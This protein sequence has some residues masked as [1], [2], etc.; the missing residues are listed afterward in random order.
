MKRFCILIAL[1]FLA[2]VLSACNESAQLVT[3]DGIDYHEEYY[4]TQDEE[5][6]AGF[7]E[8]ESGQPIIPIGFTLNGSG[9][10]DG[11]DITVYDIWT[12]A[13]SSGGISDDMDG[14]Y[15]FAEDGTIL[16]YI[17]REGAQQIMKIYS[18]AN[19]YEWFAVEFNRFRYM[20]VDAPMPQIIE[21][22]DD[23]AELDFAAEQQVS[24]AR[25]PLLAAPEQLPEPSPPPSRQPSL[26]SSEFE[27]RVFELTNAER[28]SRGLPAL[29]W[30]NEL[31]AAA[32]QHSEDMRDNGI[33]SHTGSNGSSLRSRVDNQGWPWRA[34]GENIASSPRTPESVVQGWMDST[35]HRENILNPSFTHIG[36]GTAD[37]LHTQKF[38]TPR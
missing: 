5:P 7:P 32:L 21:R 25:P 24:I 35:G 1:V 9:V 15:F 4:I 26:S 37:T 23:A 12:S 8:Y 14:F 28:T 19:W 27:V 16:G 18:A 38:G 22:P 29:T 11:F 30:S 3:E 34:L 10:F 20:R 2:A 36:V 6:E 17:S 31:A 33:F 13:V